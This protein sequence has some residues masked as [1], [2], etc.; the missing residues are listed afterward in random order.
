MRKLIIISLIILLLSGCVPKF[1]PEDEVIQEESNQTEEKAIIPRFQISDSY[2]RTLSPFK[3]SEARGL[4]AGRLN[5][6]LD[7]DEMEEGLIRIAQQIFPTDR[8]FYQDGQYLDRDTVTGWIGRYDEEKN[9][10]GLNPALKRTDDPEAN[11][12][13]HEENPIYLAHILEQNYL[14]K[15]DDDKVRLGGVAIGLAMNSVYYYREAGY[16]YEVE[17]PAD[18][19]EQRGKQMAQEIVARMRGLEGLDEVP[20]TVGIFKQQPRTSVVP[21]NYIAW[22]TVNKGKSNIEWDEMNEKYILFPSSEAEKNNREDYDQFI[23]FQ[24]DVQSYFPNYN[25]IV[26]TGFYMN[27]E[28]REMKIDVNMEFYGKSEVVGL[29]QY[30]GGLLIDTFSPEVVIEVRIQSI[31]GPEALILRKPNM[32]EP[33]VH[34]Y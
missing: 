3:P 15:T 4:T 24:E 23:K 18:E 30:I 21:G 6:R 28:L 25:G 5:T 1:D 13:A 31:S 7:S 14:V 32:D 12:R 27:N 10:Y 2:Y 20:I 34:I 8:Y 22:G 19:I 26:G 16:D 29:A 17:I 9:P 33:F 11:Q